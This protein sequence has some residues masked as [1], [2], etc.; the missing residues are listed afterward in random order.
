MGSNRSLQVKLKRIA[1]ELASHKSEL[2]QTRRYLQCILQNSKD[3]IFAT[4]VDGLLVSFSSGGEKLLGYSWKEVAGSPVKNLAYDPESFELF[5]ATCHQEGS[6]VQLDL[7]FRDKAG[8]TVYCNVSLINLTNREGQRVGTVGVC[9]DITLWKNMQED[10]VRIDRLA[11]IGRIAAGVAHEI[12][13]PLAIISEASGWAAEVI[14]DAEGLSLEARKELEKV[15][16]SISAQTKRGRRIT[17]QLL[18][19]ARDSA[20]GK[21]EFDV[22]ELLEETI[23]FLRPELKHLP[24]E[25][26]FK[27]SPGPLRIN[28]DPRMLEQIFV[29]LIAN[30]IHAIREKGGEKGRIDI[31]TLKK[32]SEVEISVEDSGVGIPEK[33]RQKIFDLFY[34]TKTAGKGTGLGLPIC[35]N[36][37]KKLGGNITFHS[38]A[39]VGTTFTVR[40]PID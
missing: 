40:I 22:H 1:Q 16:G 17:H 15:V 19:F 30:G 36:I 18:D 31:R 37:A 32:N 14:G 8:N 20:P 27:F 3:L 6:A 9:Q 4:D 7:P 28:S 38:K 39:G 13:N 12:N 10:L 23:S 2:H 34:T 33:D 11:E 5:M 29:N 24:I 21:T 35:Q 25:T 26:H